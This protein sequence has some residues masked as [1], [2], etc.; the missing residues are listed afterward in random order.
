MPLS[1]LLILLLL[2]LIRYYYIDLSH[3]PSGRMF[4]N[5]PGDSDSI[6][7]RVVPK[8]QKMVL[9]TSLLS[10]QHYKVRFKV[11]VEQSREKSH[12]LSYTSV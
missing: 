4:A 12:S 5:G 2:L 8:I 1:L 10:T 7:G 3:W 6:S 9:G 11:K